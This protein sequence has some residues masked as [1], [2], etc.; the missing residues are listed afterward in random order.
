MALCMLCIVIRCCKNWATGSLDH[1]YLRHRHSS[2]NPLIDTL[3]LHF[4]AQVTRQLTLDQHSIDILGH[5]H[6]G[7]WLIFYKYLLTHMS[8]STLGQLSSGCWWS[9]GRPSIDQCLDRELIEMSF[10]SSNPEY[11]STPD[12]RC[13]KWTWSGCSMAGIFF[14]IVCSASHDIYQW[15]S[16]PTKSLNRQ[17]EKLLQS[18]LPLATTQNVKPTVGGR[19]WKVVSYESLDWVK[20]LPH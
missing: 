1:G 4:N 12:C 3:N 15:N 7:R 13:L 10:K 20:K 9:A 5:S 16:F 2:A 19:L 6:L 18:N 14:L 11:R 17:I 8:W